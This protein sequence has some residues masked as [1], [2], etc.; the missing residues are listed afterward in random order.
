MKIFLRRY[1]KRFRSFSVMLVA[2]ALVM[3]GVAPMAKVNADDDYILT[4]TFDTNVYTATVGGGGQGIDFD[5]QNGGHGNI[6]LE[7]A[8]HTGSLGIYSVSGDQAIILISASDASSAVLSFSDNLC[9]KDG[10]DAEISG[11]NFEISGSATYNVSQN[12]PGPGG[13]N[14]APVGEWNANVNVEDGAAGTIVIEFYKTEKDA[15][16]H[17]DRI[18]L[19]EISTE[20][21]G[22]KIPDEARYISMYVKDIDTL[23]YLS[24]IGVEIRHLDGDEESRWEDFDMGPANGLFDQWRRTDEEGDYQ[25]ISV[26]LPQ[27]IDPEHDCINIRVNYSRTRSVG[28]SY[29]SGA[30]EDQYVENCKLYLLEG[31]DPAARRDGTDFQLTIGEDY[32]FLLVPDYGYQVSSLKING[33]IDIYPQDSIGVF[34]FTMVDSNFHFQGVVSPASD[35]TDTSGSSTVS[36]VSVA[37]GANATEYGGNLSVTVEDVMAPSDL[38]SV[39]DG[40]VVS[41][42]DIDIANIVSKGDGTYWSSNVTEM[43]KAIDVTLQLA[44]DMTGEGEYT[45]VREHNG[46]LTEIP[47]TYEPSTG[48]ITFSSDQFSTYTIVKKDEVKDND[49]AGTEDVVTSDADDDEEE[50]MIQVEG[51]GKN[52]TSNVTVEN[53]ASVPV[54]VTTGQNMLNALAGVTGEE[55]IVVKMEGNVGDAAK[56][57]IQ[58][59]AADANA[60]VAVVMEITLQRTTKNGVVLGKV[61][62]LEA[63]IELKVQ[64]PD[65]IDGDQYDFAI[66]RVHDGKTTILPDLDNDPKTIT[67]QSDAFSAYAVIYGEK[68]SFDSYKDG[69]VSGKTG[70][71]VSP[72]TGET[73]PYTV[74]SILLLCVGMALV[75]RNRYKQ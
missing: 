54:A 26:V 63:P 45:V 23:S 11:E 30:A 59:A 64:A 1:L 16:D 56:N 5:D 2:F 19:R 12:N 35:Q 13:G 28:W 65:F 70:S 71:K 40:R 67:V 43:D 33:W 17:V 55:N 9:I 44:P 18:E 8:D 3:S 36:A 37:N 49:D 14:N 29:D 69:A 74:V 31:K 34:K 68:G 75:M 57:V 50:D 27:Q 48:S 25:I 10:S 51:T 42:V 38:A 52:Y 47:A 62:E 41:A 60:K 58:N 24:N 46:V 20:N 72:K 22:G 39:T 4:F 61:T 21:D 32:Y 7:K 6:I 15:Q 73:E 66:V 53:T